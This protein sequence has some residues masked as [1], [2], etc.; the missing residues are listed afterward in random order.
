MDATQ[1]TIDRLVERAA[2]ALADHHFSH[3]DNL[4]RVHLMNP[5]VPFPDIGHV[6]TVNIP[7][8]VYW[9][10][11]SM[12]F[13]DRLAIA[14]QVVNTDVDAQ[15]LI[16]EYLDGDDSGGQLY[17]QI[18]PERIRELQCISRLF[19]KMPFPPTTPMGGWAAI[20]RSQLVNWICAYAFDDPIASGVKPLLTARGCTLGAKGLFHLRERKLEKL[21]AEA[22]ATVLS[23]D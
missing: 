23:A 20:S 3:R 21:R 7:D 16:G 5:P 12:T 13:A 9:V 8:A 6:Q 11:Q 22:T 14:R 4:G 18:L 19:E 17:P 10:L 15:R 1:Y 2:K